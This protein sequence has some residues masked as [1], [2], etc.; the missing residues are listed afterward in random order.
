[1]G[2]GVRVGTPLVFGIDL[3]PGVGLLGLAGGCLGE[4][5]LLIIKYFYR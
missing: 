2:G 5:P 4:M 1:M 3:V